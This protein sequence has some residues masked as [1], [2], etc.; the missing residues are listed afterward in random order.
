M[1]LVRF[2]IFKAA[3]IRT[4]KCVNRLI[5]GPT[6]TK[7]PYRN[8]NRV[9]LLVATML[10]THVPCAVAGSTLLMPT[11][12]AFPA[13][14]LTRPAAMGALHI[15]L[16]K[17]DTVTARAKFLVGFFDLSPAITNRAGCRRIA[18]PDLPYCLFQDTFAVTART[19]DP[20]GL[21]NLTAPIA[22]RAFPL[23]IPSTIAKRAFDFARAIAGRAIR[24][25]PISLARATLDLA[26]TI[27]IRTVTH[28]LILLLVFKLLWRLLDPLQPSPTRN[29]AKRK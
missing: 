10:A 26:R 8:T 28:D 25:A 6:E 13:N 14:G 11:A 29:I 5:M 12:A 7:L 4:F 20:P 18:S 2:R 19:I 21:L 15:A 22:N 23:C 27:A 17:M 16:Q 24:E 3:L 9:F 1:T